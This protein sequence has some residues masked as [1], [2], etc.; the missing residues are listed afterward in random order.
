MIL[1]K[2]DHQQFLLEMMKQV[3]FPGSLL[4]LA[5]EIKK[6]IESAEIKES[7]SKGNQ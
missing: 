7:A 5:Y 2:K 6:A 4:D 1:D 3:N